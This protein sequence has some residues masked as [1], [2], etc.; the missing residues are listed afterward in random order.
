MNIPSNIN[1]S[2][3][4]LKHENANSSLT[5]LVNKSS[6]WTIFFYFSNILSSY[7]YFLNLLGCRCPTLLPSLKVFQSRSTLRFCLD[8]SCARQ[9]LI[10][11]RNSSFLNF[12]LMKLVLI[13]SCKF[14]PFLKVFIS[15]LLTT[16]FVLDVSG[17]LS[18]RTS[19]SV[20]HVL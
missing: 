18:I 1:H 4:G 16:L 17:R 14:T 19:K 20:S 8:S 5:L 13:W 3:L 15:V 9:N 2:M 6:T 10:H 11:P 7:F 12:S